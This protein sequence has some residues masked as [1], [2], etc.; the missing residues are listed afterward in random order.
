MN[1]NLLRNTRVYLSVPMD[2]VGS[3]VVEKYFGWR[4]ILT[5]VLKALSISVLDPWNKP[6]VLGHTLEYGREGLLPAKDRY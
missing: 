2:F 3:R 4:A 1:G 6:R 5:P